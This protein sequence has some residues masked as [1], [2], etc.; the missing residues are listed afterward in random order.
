MANPYF[1]K[2]NKWCLSLLAKKFY[3]AVAASLHQPST[4]PCGIY[5]IINTCPTPP[6]VSIHLSVYIPPFQPLH[7][8]Q[9]EWDNRNRR[10]RGIWR[11]ASLLY[12]LEPCYFS[13]PAIKFVKIQGMTKEWK[14]VEKVNL[15]SLLV[16]TDGRTLI[17]RRGRVRPHSSLAQSV[18]LITK[19][20]LSGRS[21]WK[22]WQ[23]TQ[24]ESFW[25]LWLC[26][27]IGLC[28]YWYCY[29]TVAGVLPAYRALIWKPWWCAD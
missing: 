4:L 6:L 28:R 25:E 16:L 24:S 15:K 9:P 13:I 17:T 23:L 3:S 8:L 7:P 18:A 12:A 22:R 26:C 19:V 29:R 11:D 10:W 21:S 27:L 5:A 14:L 2:W 1:Y 20:Q